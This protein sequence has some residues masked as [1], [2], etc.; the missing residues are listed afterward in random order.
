MAQTSTTKSN[1]LRMAIPD[2]RADAL[3]AQH[4]YQDPRHPGQHEA[5]IATP[6]SRPKVWAVIRYLQ[7]ADTAE[8]AA[9]Y[10][11]SPAAIEAVVAYY[12]RHRDLID[13]KILLENEEWA[14]S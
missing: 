5:Q 1:L 12:R 6:S 14:A 8:V 7:A 10:D 2:D 4:I 9:T 11:L 3:I 13:A